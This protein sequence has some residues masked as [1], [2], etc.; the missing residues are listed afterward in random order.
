MGQRDATVTQQREAIDMAR[1]G[2]CAAAH[3]GRLTLGKVLAHQAV[4][5]IASQRIT[6][7]QA[8]HQVE[9]WS[10]LECTTIRYY[11]YRYVEAP[12]V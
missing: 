11:P 7:N 12:S 6:D 8:L 5:D 2:C 3:R 1:S 9:T 4:V 10:E